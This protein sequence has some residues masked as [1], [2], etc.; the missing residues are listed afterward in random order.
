[1]TENLNNQEVRS[2]QH[3]ANEKVNSLEEGNQALIYAGNVQEFQ[4]QQAI[5][6][7]SKEAESWRILQ[8]AKEDAAAAGTGLPDG[9]SAKVDG[10][11]ARGGLVKRGNSYIVGEKGPELYTPAVSGRIT[12]NNQMQKETSHRDIVDVNFSINGSEP[13]PLQGRRSSVEELKYQLK[14]Q[15]RYAA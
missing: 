10:A 9:Q 5:L 3:K 11:R 13:I 4:T 7:N 12:P 6:R 2:D 8:R 15:Q 1:M 14:E